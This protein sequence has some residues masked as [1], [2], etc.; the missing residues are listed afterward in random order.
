MV[1]HEEPPHPSRASDTDRLTHASTGRPWRT[2]AEWNA[3]RS[4]IA[5]AEA[6]RSTRRRWPRVAVGSA[7]A[8]LVLFAAGVVAQRERNAASPWHVASAPA[9]GRT[10]VQLDDRSVVTLG[11][12]STMRYRMNGSAR[13]VELHGLAQFS[14]VHDTQ[15]P[16]RVRAA[17]AVATDVG[18]DF[19]VRAYDEDSVVQVSVTSGEVMLSSAR[20]SVQLLHGAV[21]AVDRS[22]AARRDTRADAASHSAWVEG[23]LQF[24]N[25]TVEEV[26]V[27]LARWFNVTV[28]VADP[29][30]RARHVTAVYSS[31]TLRGVLDA[32]RATVDMTYDLDDG[33][34]TV[35]LRAAQ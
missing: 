13:E 8:A 34:R 31:P 25:A 26:A 30:L 4:R 24:D 32:L 23:R 5:E 22:G 17:N 6:T 14:V 18:T 28:R 1:D 35:T 29:A 16:F 11:P 19:V 12:A 7:A 21:G 3:L 15:R 9:G 20:D 33:A 2:D 27:E 10:R